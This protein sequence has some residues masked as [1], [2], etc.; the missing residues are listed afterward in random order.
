MKLLVIMKYIVNLPL[1]WL[2]I[3][4][5]RNKNIWIFGAWFGQ[6]YA[7][8]CKTLF[9][10]VLK[11]DKQIRAI[12]LTKN[13][14]VY[15]RLREEGKEVYFIYSIKG[16]FYSMLAGYYIVSSGL[17]DINK[18]VKGGSVKIINLWHGTPLKM[19]GCDQNKNFNYR[20]KQASFALKLKSYIFPFLKN[21]Y[22]YVLSSSKKIGTLLKSAFMVTE[23]QI[24]NLG[25]P[26]N[27]VLKER[28]ESGKK[29]ILFLP[30]FRDVSGFNIFE[31]FDSK[32]FNEFLEK[33]GAV[34]YYKLHPADSNNKN[35][36]QDTNIINLDS[37]IDL[38]E[39]LKS[40]DIL[41][42]DYSS[43]Y[44][45]FLLTQK[46]IVFTPFDIDTYIS[47]DRRLY[48]DY[49]SVTPG[50]KCRNWQ[51]VIG[52]IDDLLQ[53]K[54]SYLAQR[55]VLNREFNEN[56]SFDSTQKVY[57]FIKKKIN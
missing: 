19:I 18:Y 37:N 30:T 41:L 51:E 2:S 53:G 44:F 4:I 23:E 36:P 28:V 45:D 1:Y 46:P 6:K 48:Y 54:D 43:I 5:P 52:E 13:K 40:V 33:N 57:Q 16:Y 38:Y 27:D 9:E 34:F 42:T 49:E 15:K 22:N 24:I 20:N 32:M 21:D 29:T 55:E 26:R 56:R 14:D 8:N 25:Y 10:F 17:V 47:K 50:P 31:N 39:F 7:D 35:N 11:N 12:W 3:V